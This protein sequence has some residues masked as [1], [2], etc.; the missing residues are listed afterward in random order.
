MDDI[1]RMSPYERRAWTEAIERL[2]RRDESAA[3]RLASRVSAPV[4][5]TAVKVWAKVPLHGDVEGLVTQ[6]LQGL[7]TVT[8]GPAMNS[9]NPAKVAKRVGSPFEQFHTLDLQMLDK[10]VPRTRW[11]YTLGAMAEGG[12]TAIVVTGAEVSSTVSGGTTAAVA[13]A[14]VATDIAASIGIMGRIVAK[15]AAHYGYDTSLPEEELFVLGVISLGT[16]GSPASKTQALSSLSR[17]T[18]QMMRQPTWAQLNKNAWVQLVQKVFDALG[19]KLTQQKL[20]Q[21]IPFLGVLVN[22]GLSAEMADRTFRRARDAYRLRFLADKYGIDP[23]EWLVEPN[24]PPPDDVLSAALESLETRQGYDD[25]K[26]APTSE[27]SSA[28]TER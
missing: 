1:S 23:A 16:A 3:R 11:Y 9:V 26:N 27:T 4:K 12:T 2:N 6:S 5:S 22:G 8:F 25:E 17:L 10:A 21:A 19:L 13:V 7:F 28:E 15:V 14:A 18:Q 20:G 24:E